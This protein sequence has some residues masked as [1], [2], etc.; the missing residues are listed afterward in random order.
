M[1]G[2][3]RGRSGGVELDEAC[4][5][6]EVYHTNLASILGGSDKTRSSQ[7]LVLETPF[8]S[9]AVNATS[10]W[11]GAKMKYWA[12]GDIP[13]IMELYNKEHDPVNLTL[14]ISRSENQICMLKVKVCQTAQGL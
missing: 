11:R 4:S 10:I 6:T 5:R 12:V 2:L 7:S 1:H 8:A 13:F 9:F 3:G 14:F